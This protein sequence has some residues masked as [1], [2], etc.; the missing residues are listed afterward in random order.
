[1]CCQDDCLWQKL[2]E[3]KWGMQ[4]NELAEQAKA[5]AW[6][7]YVRHRTAFKTIRLGASS[8]GASDRLQ[9]NLGFR[10]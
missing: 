10:R 4:V 5:K 9:A 1:M 2:A 3:A 8:S 7:D 6:I